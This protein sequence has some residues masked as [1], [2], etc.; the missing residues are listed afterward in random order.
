[1]KNNFFISSL[2]LF[3]IQII[4]SIKFRNSIQLEANTSK[5]EN[6]SL[7]AKERKKNKGDEG[8][9]YWHGLK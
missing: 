6:K 7:N 4:S 8:D 2:F 9:E 1:M 5:L 3:F